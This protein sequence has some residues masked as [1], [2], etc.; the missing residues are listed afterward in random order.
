MEYISLKSSYS[1]IYQI[2]KLLKI[3]EYRRAF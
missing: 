2:Y 1:E 3:Q